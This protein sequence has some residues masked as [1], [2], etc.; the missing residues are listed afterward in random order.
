MP[1]GI[2]GRHKFECEIL[3]RIARIDA[4]ATDGLPAGAKDECDKCGEDDVGYPVFH[5]LGKK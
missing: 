3:F 2:S 4:N 5:D 1:S